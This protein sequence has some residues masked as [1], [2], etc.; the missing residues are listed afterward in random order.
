MA[1]L[2]HTA[3]WHLG[4]T[5]H[6]RDLLTDQA[7]RLETLLR[8]A[9]DERPDAVL[10]AGD[11]Y[12]RAAPPVAAIEL[13]DEVLSRLVLDLR[14]PVVVIAGNHDSPERLGYG[15]RLVAD[16]L[17]LVGPWDPDRRPRV[18][19]TTTGP[20]AIHAVPYAD[21]VV[22]REQRP[23]AALD[24]ASAFRA[25]LDAA[26][27]HAS[28][29]AR[30]ILVAHAWVDGASPTESE[31]PLAPSTTGA[32]PGS[33]LDGWTYVALGHVHRPQ[34]VRAPTPA[35]YPGSLMPY[36][37]SEAGQERGV[38]LTEI[39]AFG[40]VA[41]RSIPL[42]GT[43]EVREIEGTLHALLRPAIGADTDDYVFAR[44]TDGPHLDAAA[45]LR[46][47]WPNLLGVDA[48]AEAAPSARPAAARLGPG[49]AMDPIALAQDFFAEVLGESMT[50]DDRSLLDE[51]LRE[52]EREA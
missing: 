31:R 46:G 42:G 29:H 45:R 30:N 52:L 24:H 32:V 1:R 6:G 33:T 18:L 36:S 37:R 43:R 19:D 3:D 26:R 51:V 20:L 13:L 27:A 15:A 8:V 50:E 25:Q 21:P 44:L 16:G 7:E 14:L 12:D 22:V 17:L 28:A 47:V 9:A 5:L 35:W 4:R 39:S 2:L 11:V 38:L 10:I 41:T 34:R 40:A 23:L 49:G 48:T